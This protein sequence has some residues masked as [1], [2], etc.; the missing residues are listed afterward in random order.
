MY[1]QARRIPTILIVTCLALSALLSSINIVRA[2]GDRVMET[3]RSIA[4]ACELMGGT[5]EIEMVPGNDGVILGTYVTCS[6][7]IGDFGCDVGGTPEQDPFVAC[8]AGRVLET[9][10]VAMGPGDVAD[11]GENSG[12][13]TS[14]AVGGAVPSD[15]V[16]EDPSRGMEVTTSTRATTDELVVACESLGGVATVDTHGGIGYTNVHCRGGVLDGTTCIVGH[17]DTYCTYYRVATDPAVL[18]DLTPDAVPALLEDASWDGEVIV[19]NQSGATVDSAAMQTA[20]C[21]LFGGSG[22]AGYDFDEEGNETESRAS[23]TGGLLDGMI[24]QNYPDESICLFRAVAPESVQVD[25][26][27]GNEMPAER[28]PVAPSP[29]AQPTEVIV[30]NPTPTSEPTV[31][32]TSQPTVA[33]T[34]AP[35]EPVEP[36]VFPTPPTDDIAV[37]PGEAEDPVIE[38]TPT[39]VVLT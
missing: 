25:P 17:Y 20:L 15:G 1:S 31:M 33:P 13:Q 16:A 24:C 23:C 11:P 3:S 4:V 28:A 32:P 7:A 5:A 6:T 19:F 9:Q 35:T 34:V 29:T 38:P 2:A 26:N 37:P 27:A 21:G 8:S 30:A 36:P 18:D 10:T 39:E 12:G 14:V 22:K